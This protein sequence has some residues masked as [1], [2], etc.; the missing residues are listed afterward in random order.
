[1]VRQAEKGGLEG[2][3]LLDVRQVASLLNVSPRSVWRMAAA[4][5]A[6]IGCFPRALRL[7]PRCVRW[8]ACD[9]EAYLQ[10]LAGGR[11]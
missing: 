3:R 6:G 8:R 1:M 4:S 2:L 9:I 11:G 7:S 10:S 5:E